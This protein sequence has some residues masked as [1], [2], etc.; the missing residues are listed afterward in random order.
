M[1][2]RTALAPLTDNLVDDAAVFPPGCATPERAWV[3]YLA[4]R[5]TRYAVSVGPLLIARPGT[6]MAGTTKALRRL[7]ELGVD[8]IAIAGVEFAYQ[9]GW[10]E[11]LQWGLPVA[12]EVPGASARQHEALDEIV[13]TG[14]RAKLRTQS[15]PDQP[16]PTA[17]DVAH[18]IA[19][20]VGRDIAFKLTGG[21]HRAVAHT[22]RSP[23]V[24]EDRHG[25]LNVMAA[26]RHALDGDA[27][28]ALTSW[29]V[30]RDP[31]TLVAAIQP[32]RGPDLIRM[33]AAFTSFG[34]CGV[35]DP[36]RDLEDLHLLRAPEATTP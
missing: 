34:C 21:L 8:S 15:T 23:D 11:A 19:G 18:F 20:C 1:S 30:E 5:H 3:D 26:T 24:V 29:L 12:L 33:R 9:P 32:L 7:E 10:R 36:L 27:Q 6:S 2:T 14:A 35:L 28:G 16:V 13:G 4:R 31:A 25:V 22:S 17:N